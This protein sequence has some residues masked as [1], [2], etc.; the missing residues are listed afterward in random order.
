M[1]A[2]RKNCFP[3]TAKVLLTLATAV[4]VSGCAV[5]KDFYATGGSRAD[6]TVDMAYDFRQFEK[7]VINQQQ[8]LSIAKSKC[9]VWGYGDAEAFGG[10]TQNCQQR[11][12]WG[13]CVAGQTVIKYQCIG[14]IDAVA[15]ARSFSPSAASVG[16]PLSEQAYKQQQVDQLMQQN[17]PYAEYQQR[18]QQIMGQ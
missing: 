3:L 17:L 5:K 6:G 7:P 1:R 18:Y 13:T 12:G 8:A 10:M 2:T 16:Q 15:P 11:D 4:V 14:N 9:A